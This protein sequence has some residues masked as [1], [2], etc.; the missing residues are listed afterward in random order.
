MLYCLVAKTLKSLMPVSLYVLFFFRKIR[1][2]WVENMFPDQHFQI[3]NVPSIST[4][5]IRTNSGLVVWHDVLTK[6]IEVYC[7]VV[8]IYFCVF[9]YCLTLWCRK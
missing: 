1:V 6:C 2:F 7:S 9:S 5:F 8:F 4:Q 3:L